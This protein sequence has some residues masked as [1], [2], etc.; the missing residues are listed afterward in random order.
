VI[1]YANLKHARV[2]VTTIPDETTS[3]LIVTAAKDLNPDLPVIARAATEQGLRLLAQAGASIIVHPE[4]EGGLEM[5]HHTLLRLGFPLHEVHQYAEAVR[6]DHYD[7]EVTTNEEHRSIH[8]LLM[9]L[10][11][12]EIIWMEL[13]TASPLVGKS[14]AEANLRSQTGASVVALVREQ[15]LIA[16]PKSVTVFEAGDRIGVIGE[17]DQIEVVQSLVSQ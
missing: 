13:T 8:D 10:K 12:I 7:F 5:V 6:H 15:Q 17:K 11:G 4:L 1:N 2:L 14:L 9:A 16:N 3:M